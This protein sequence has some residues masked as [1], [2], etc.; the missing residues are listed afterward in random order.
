MLPEALD[1][2]RHQHPAPE[3]AAWDVV[4]VGGG[5]AGVEAALAAARLGAR[6]A[7]VT[8]RADLLGEMSCNPAIGGLGKGQLVKEVD[9]LGGL[10]GRVADAT[11]LQFRMLGTRKGAAVRAP[12]CQSDRH[13][14]RAAVVAAVAASAVEVVE[15]SVTGLV[16]S[17]GSHA[18][19]AGAGARGPW[20][21]GVRLADWRELDASAVVLTTGT[22]LRAI[23]HVGETRSEGGRA[24]EAAAVGLDADFARLGLATGRLKTGTP[25]RLVADSIA[26][27]ALDVQHGDARPVPFSWRTDRARFPALDQR[28]CHVTY[29][30]DATHAL[31]RANLHRAP[32]YSGAIQGVGP[33][34]CPSVEDK[35]MRFADKERHQVFLEPEG[36]DTDWVYANGVSTSLPAEVQEAMLRTIPGL[37]RVRFHRHGYA[38]EY[39]FVQPSQLD[40]EL[41]VRSVPGLY[42]AGQLNGTSGYEEAAAQGLVAGANA[43]L[44]G[45]GR[46]PLVLARHEAYTGVLVDDLVVTNPT[47]PYRMFTSRA[48]YRLLL[49]HDTADRRLTPRGH[50]LGLVSDADHAAYLARERE[51]AA[52]RAYLERERH[53]GKTLAELLRRPA[54]DW[55]ALEALSPGLAALALDPELAQVL[56]SDVKYAGYVENQLEDVARLAR[57]EAAEIP[58]DFDYAG[59]SGLA[60]EARER[61]GRLR[62]RTL[63]AASRVAGIRPPDVALLAV[64]LE[65]RRRAERASGAGA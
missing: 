29:T 20:V 53:E 36:L 34:Y 56:E 12:R 41:A 26:W 21:R 3:R 13:R 42:L 40:G 57:Q 61:L 31:I 22:F 28:P 54:L 19:L 30:N 51:L 50:A 17:E 32:M 37:E 4:V 16:L 15:G 33:R 60:H 9:A 52:A 18:H 25:P 8:F 24:G 23:M 14:Y 43:A 49:R 10:M 65:R 46:E 5:H 39:D 27:D 2:P 6:T 59:V 48:E 11:G 63:G 44:W 35:V 58:P 45:L 38:V 62:P 1:P 47:E 7:L 64:H 55:A